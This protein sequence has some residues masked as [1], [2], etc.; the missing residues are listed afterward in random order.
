MKF[1]AIAV[2][3]VAAGSMALAGSQSAL[4]DVDAA[5]YR[6]VLADAQRDI[7]KNHY[8]PALRGVN[9]VAL[10][11][12]AELKL[13][14]SGSTAAAIDAITGVFDSFDDSHT[15]FYPPQRSTRVDYG[16]TMSAVG[17]E[18][19]VLKVDPDSDAAAQGLTPGDRVLAINRFLPT[20]A[21]LSRIRH[22]YQIIRPQS[23]QRVTVRRPDGA[24]R[25]LDIRSKVE[26]RELVQ[27]MDAFEE[28]VADAPR[29]AD[30]LV[31]PGIL[32]WRLAEFRDGDARYAGA[33]RLKSAKALVLDLRGNPGGDVEGLKAMAGVLLGRPA[34]LMTMV[35]RKGAKSETAKPKGK[36]FP[37][38]LVVMIDSRSASASEIL[39]RLVQLQKRGTVIGDRSAG[40][41]MV[42][43]MFVHAF[44]LASI[45]F[46]ANSVTVADVLMPD[47]GRLDGRGVTPDELLL[48]A[49]AD[50]A[51]G[52]DPVLA[53]AIAL[54]GGTISAED[55]GKLL[56]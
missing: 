50:L 24:E 15:R 41:V 43:E 11:K 51:A 47:G 13:A 7:Q 16:W 9:L 6:R 31:E 38:T 2:L 49:Q 28:A 20:R 29:D 36:P 46:Y 17:E 1:R 26:R 37:G 23:Q 12:T 4:S 30:K 14:G 5:L 3:A 18:P 10:V 42:S 53:R 54:A 33:S 19:L 39:A 27:L 34:D 48:P 21:S 32:V 25:A 22:Y 55:A 52:R 45:T 56:R 35:T 8:D 44:G 40:A